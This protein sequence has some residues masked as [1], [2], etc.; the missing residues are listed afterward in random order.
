MSDVPAPRRCSAAAGFSCGFAR[1]LASPVV[2]GVL[3]RGVL[4]AVATLFPASVRGD[5]VAVCGG[6]DRPVEDSPGAGAHAGLVF[7]M[8]G[9]AAATFFLQYG[10]VRLTPAKRLPFL[11][12]DRVDAAA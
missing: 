2:A 10:D 5:A 3:G 1:V 4:I 11:V 6:G 12:L 9:A 7:P 8:L